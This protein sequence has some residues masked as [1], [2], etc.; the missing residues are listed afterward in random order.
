MASKTFKQWVLNDAKGFESL[1]I[2]SSTIPTAINDYDVLVNLHFASLN[3]RDIIIA[4]VGA[5]LLI[6]P[7]YLCIF[8]SR[9]TNTINNDR[10]I[11]R[12]P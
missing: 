4:Q 3:Y 6:P 7:P 1:Q 12:F 8:E 2:S 11:T 10:G 5:C 9:F